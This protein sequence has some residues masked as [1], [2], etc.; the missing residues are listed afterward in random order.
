MVDAAAVPITSAR[1]RAGS[2][3]ATKVECPPAQ[4]AS[5]MA[6]AVVV[7]PTPPVP[8]HTITR[9]IRALSR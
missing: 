1:R 3:V 9:V 4:S 7:L 6:A 8:I 2:V 5:A